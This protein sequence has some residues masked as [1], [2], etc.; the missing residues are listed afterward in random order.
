[1]VLYVIFVSLRVV[2]KKRLQRININK[3]RDKL[4]KV[5]EGISTSVIGSSLFFDDY[6]E[7]TGYGSGWADNFTLETPATL[8][9]LDNLDKIINQHQ[10]FTGADVDA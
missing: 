2:M 6:F 3:R 4:K 7:G 5:L 8:F 10:G 9:R 1:M